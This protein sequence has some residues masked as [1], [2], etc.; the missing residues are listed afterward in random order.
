MC[1]GGARKLYQRVLCDTHVAVSRDQCNA[2]RAAAHAWARVVW[3][4]GRGA[5]ARRCKNFVS[6]VTVCTIPKT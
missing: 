2:R 4:A 5:A 3:G 6:C 1:W